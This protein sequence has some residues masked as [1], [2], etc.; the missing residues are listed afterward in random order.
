MR[1]S[2]ISAHEVADYT[3]CPRSWYLKRVK[4]ISIDTEQMKNG[5]ELHASHGNQLERAVRAKVFARAA[6][7]LALVAIIVAIILA[8][9]GGGY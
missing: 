9:F 2:S 5:R 6:V 4:G 1:K 8:A 7:R 3:F